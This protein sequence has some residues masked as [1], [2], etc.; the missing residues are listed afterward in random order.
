[1]FKLLCLH[2]EKRWLISYEHKSKAP[3]QWFGCAAIR[4]WRSS[5]TVRSFKIARLL[6]NIY[7]LLGPTVHS[8]K[9]SLL[10]TNSTNSMPSSHHKLSS[11][12]LFI[13][14]F[15]PFFSFF[16]VF[17]ELTILFFYSFS[18]LMRFFLYFFIFQ[19]L[20]ERNKIQF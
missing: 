19:Q 9:R 13:F 17:N 12:L 2:S 1:M 6:L 15:Y 8:K 10:W 20:K 18:G 16:Y 3:I 14:L 7:R 4:I 5:Q 11:F